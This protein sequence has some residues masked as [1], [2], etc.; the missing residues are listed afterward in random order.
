MKQGIGAARHCTFDDGVQ[1]FEKVVK[2]ND[3]QGYTLKTTKFIQ[4]PM[5]E[6]EIT[7]SLR[8]DGGSTIVSQSMSYQMKGGLFAPIM[9]IMAK[10]MMRK[11]LNGALS[12]LK[13]Y[14]EKQS[15]P[16]QQNDLHGN[17]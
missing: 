11:V 1:L 17:H 2:W 16:A 3:G 10:G 14:V 13:E 4:V 5:K 9:A 12:G 6:N 15:I 7:F 8:S